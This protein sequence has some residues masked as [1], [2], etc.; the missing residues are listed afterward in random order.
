[1]V[2]QYEVTIRD[3]RNVIVHTYK[4]NNRQQLY[5]NLSVW[6][7]QKQLEITITNPQDEIFATKPLGKPKFVYNNRY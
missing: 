6:E 3:S 1:M 5:R 4:Y 2:N 7:S